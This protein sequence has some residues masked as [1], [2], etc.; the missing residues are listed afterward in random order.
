MFKISERIVK[1]NQDIS[2][3]RI[4]NNVDGVLAVRMLQRS[5]K[6]ASFLELLAERV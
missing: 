4:E 1:T 3:Q 2:E 5:R 6:K